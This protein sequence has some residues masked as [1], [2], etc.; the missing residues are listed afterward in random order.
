MFAAA[1]G[2]ADADAVILDALDVLLHGVPID[3]SARVS[4]DACALP[5]VDTTDF[6]TALVPAVPPPPGAATDGDIVRDVRPG[7]A[8]GLAVH[9]RNTTV[10]AGPTPRIL[11]VH[12]EILGDDRLIL[13][14]RT[15]HVIVPAAGPCD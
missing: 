1:S 6:V 4:P 5:A 9:L 7:D 2:G 10:A 12:V 8:V 11:D 3:V 14:T 13:D 15:I